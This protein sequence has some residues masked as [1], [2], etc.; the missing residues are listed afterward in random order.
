MSGLTTTPR[1]AHVGC[2]DCDDFVGDFSA[3]ASSTGF[4]FVAARL[5]APAPGGACPPPLSGP[6]AAAL[7]RGSA[8]SP[9]LMG[10]LE[11]A[12]EASLLRALSL[13]DHMGLPAAALRVA[14]FPGGPVECGRALARVC[15]LR[16]SHA[17]LPLLCARVA[18][19]D[20]GGGW[21]AWHCVRALC[22]RG[23]AALGACVE[24][25]AELPPPAAQQRWVAEPLHVA[26]LPTALFSLNGAGFPTLPAGHQQLVARLVAHGVALLVEGA[27]AAGV[28]AAA[29]AQAA[30]VARGEVA[31]DAQA[32]AWV[33]A[34]PLRAYAAYLRHVGAKLLPAV[35]AEEAAMAPWADALQCPL[36]P[37]SDH[38]ENAM[39]EVFERDAPKYEAYE[40]AMRAALAAR[41]AGGGGGGGGRPVRCCVA[42]AGRGP[43][44]R[45][46]LAAADA[47]GVP[48]RVW[49]VEKNPNAALH[50]AAVGAAEGWA[51]RGVAAVVHAD[52]RTWEGPA[53]GGG[54]FDLLVSELL[55]SF[56]DNELSP[57][58]LGDAEPLLAPG[59]ASIPC[60]YTSYLA[61]LSSA[62]LWAAAFARGSCESLYVVRA[63]RAAPLAPPAP[64]FTF[65]HPGHEVGSGRRSAR[66][67]FD[68]GAV[69][70]LP[71]LLH[72]FSGYFSAVLWDGGEGAGGGCGGGGGGGGGGAI[73]LC[74]LPASHAPAD[75]LSWFPL[76]LPLAEPVL[77]ERG[78]RLVLQLWR[79]VEE[80]APLAAAGDGLQPRRRGAPGRVW[81]EWALLEPRV[82]AIHNVGGRAAVMLL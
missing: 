60:E 33:A 59:G 31:G 51:A 2:T 77:V 6:V 41:A 14:A 46:L 56:G 37:L 38:L 68:A 12:C 27:P 73:R 32:L 79:C 81:F 18:L 54:G 49:A 65:R 67:E 30:A 64:A 76:F 48:V 55:G 15:A 42:G 57:E 62:K 20:G 22:G 24:V 52:A 29:A 72:G 63:L 47:V 70:A 36:Q 10:L 80:G 66:L 45:R 78:Q 28:G 69:G 4:D 17:G 7:L 75:M 71:A 16:G 34:A 3:P 58:C 25:G 40:G 26:V 82:S 39:Y 1:L 61:P 9:R 44:V 8:C 35:G 21:R 19:D 11:G 53:D 13:A 43:L 5:C 23:A 74:T 50:L